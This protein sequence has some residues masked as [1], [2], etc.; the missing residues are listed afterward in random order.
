MMLVLESSWDPKALTKPEVGGLRAIIDKIDPGLVGTRTS[1][2]SNIPLQ[3]I[4]RGLD[5]GT[6]GN[7]TNS[8]FMFRL[9]CLLGLQQARQH[10]KMQEMAPTAIDIY[11]VSYTR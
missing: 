4:A 11:R 3:G 1:C 7:P 2:L 6:G 8:P 9:L 5:I 10:L